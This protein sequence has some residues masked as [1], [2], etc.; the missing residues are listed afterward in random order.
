VRVMVSLLLYL[1]FSLMLDSAMI[2][3]L[4]GILIVRCAPPGHEGSCEALAQS[5]Q[6]RPY[7]PPARS[8][9]GVHIPYGRFLHTCLFLT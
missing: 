5:F 7:N 2:R 6:L 3:K 1:T 9:P 8:L 4:W